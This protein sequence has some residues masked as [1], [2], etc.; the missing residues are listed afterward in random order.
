MIPHPSSQKIWI[1]P[2]Y[3]PEHFRQVRRLLYVYG[4][5]RN[6]DAAL[7]NYFEEL[8]S[9]STKYGGAEGYLLFAQKN[10]RAIGCVAFRYESEGIVEM[11]RLYVDAEARG[12]KVGEQLCLRLIQIAQ[13]RG[14]QKMR[15][16]THPSMKSA[17]K[18]YQVLGFYEIG[19]YNDNPIPGIRFFEKKLI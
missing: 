7:G 14:F 9:L 11:K 4:M 13:K 5:S 2:A 8:A 17:Q 3:K 10:R 6:L 19:R 15:L 16:D 12:Q 18:L 1:R